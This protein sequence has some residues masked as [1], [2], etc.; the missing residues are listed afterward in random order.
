MSVKDI[1]GG[2]SHNLKVKKL[3]LAFIAVIC[4]TIFIWV[5]ERTPPATTFFSSSSQ[6]DI[7]SNI[8]SPV[9][10]ISTPPVTKSL[11]KNV[12]SVPPTKESPSESATLHNPSEPKIPVS[13]LVSPATGGSDQNSSVDIKR[14][15]NVDMVTSDKK[16]CNYAK[17]RW[18]A[19]N[20]RPLY[21]GFDCKQWLSGMWSCRLNRRTDFSF[22]NYRWQP[23]NCEMPE[24]HASKFLSR[25][26]DKTI[27]FVGDSLG[28]QQFQ[29][30]M[31]MVTGG[32]E[33]PNVKDIGSQY[34][35]IKRPG[36][37]RPDGWAYLFPETNTT[38]LYYW[39]ASLCELEPINKTDPSTNYAMHLDRPAYFIKHY[40]HRFDV[41]VLNTGHHWNRVKFAAN[42]WKM[43]LNGMP[44]TD[45]KIANINK[46][47]SL[48]IH[49]ITKWLDAQM[50]NYPRLK[51]FFRTLSPRHFVNGDWN[52]GGSCDNTHPLASGSEINKDGSDDAV[53][54]DAVKGTRIDL[55][56]I[57]ALS[58]LR[59]EGHISNNSIRGTPGSYDCLHWCLPGIPDTWNELLA[60]QI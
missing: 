26:R 10:P 43:H 2:G 48:T 21:S 41:L 47:R 34:G 49:S 52:S 8:L 45:P 23:Y 14:D 59:D 27:A 33:D 35:L 25:M 19:D 9:I 28:R 40:L 22:E 36:A 50:S 37:I 4:F 5:R 3:S 55:L 60:V 46:A 31:C 1:K 17:G 12:S 51:V 38:I 42:R 30:L 54:E 32:K 56:D 11:S 6:F 16:D 13:E 15:S 29:S 57:T 58:H 18:V 39:S 7:R 44:V 53:T 24:F 20:N